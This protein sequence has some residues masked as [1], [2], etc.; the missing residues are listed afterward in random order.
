MVA[1]GISSVL[2]GIH[3]NHILKTFR[4]NHD[5]CRTM[6]QVY[7]MGERRIILSESKIDR[8]IINHLP[9][10]RICDQIRS[11]RSGSQ[12]IGLGRCYKRM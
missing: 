2:Y 7:R 3:Q 10:S 8:P 6:I 12:I 11:P 5:C 4:E 9:K 1:I